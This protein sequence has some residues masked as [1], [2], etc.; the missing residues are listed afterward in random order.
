MSPEEYELGAV[1]DGVTNVFALG[2]VAHSL[3]GGD[4]TKSG[5]A[6]I[7]SEQQ[8][9]VVA[10]ALQPVRRDRWGSIAELVAA[11]RHSV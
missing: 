1:I 11:W 7:G 5:D 2:A 4:R 6:W 8:Y 10:R 9:Q 3:L